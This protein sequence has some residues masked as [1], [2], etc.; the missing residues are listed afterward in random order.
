MN[1]L[2]TAKFVAENVRDSQQQ[3]SDFKPLNRVLAQNIVNRQRFESE[4]GLNTKGF[5]Q[6]ETPNMARKGPPVKKP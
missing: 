4:Q 5:S 3:Q 2:D 6:S 1:S